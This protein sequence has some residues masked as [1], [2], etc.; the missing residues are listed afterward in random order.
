MAITTY[1]ELKT[2]VANWLNRDDLTSNIPEFIALAEAAINDQV[3]HWRMEKRAETT[4]DAQFI[5][6]PSDWLETVRFHINGNG[7]T[8]VRYVPRADMQKMRAANEDATG[9]PEYYSHNAGQVELYPTPDSNYSA[10]INYL[11]QVA[12]LSDV[13]T[14]NWLL[15]NY[16]DVYLYGALIHSAPFLQEDERTQTWAAMYSSAV[17]RANKASNKAVASGSGLKVRIGAYK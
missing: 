2:A 4:L 10:D 11:A 7:T 5:G 9:T 3:R 14:T 1:S 15:T 6:L 17:A 13:N 16:P 8:D 12:A